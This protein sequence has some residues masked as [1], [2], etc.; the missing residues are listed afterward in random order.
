MKIGFSTLACPDWDLGTVVARASG[1]GFNGVELRGLRGEFRL[2]SVA[3]LAGDIDYTRKLFE[4][5]RVELIALSPSASLDSRKSGVI[6]ENMEN[7]REH[8]ELARRLGCPYVKIFAGEIQRWDHRDAA[9]S[10]ISMR[11]REIIPSAVRA[12][13]TLLVENTGDF[14]TSDDIWYLLDAVGHPAV[15]CCWNQVH[16]MTR[17]EGPTVSIPRLGRRIAVS[18]ICDAEFDEDG[19][20]LNYKLPGMGHVGVAR[21]IELLRGV[22]NNGFLV[23]EWPKAW[24]PSLT[25]PDTALPSV[26]DFLKKQLAAKQAVLSAYKGDKNAPRFRTGHRG[27]TERPVEP[28]KSH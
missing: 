14:V 19:V 7:I 16:A 2:G 18:H 13:V 8:I 28:V 9:L 11:L 27:P 20:L 5:A 25:D 26:A 24:L 15:Q 6:A 12:G 22:G 4:E 3:A 1:M 10:R 17:R 21:Q 23:F